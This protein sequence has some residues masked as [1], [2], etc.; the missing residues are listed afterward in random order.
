[1]FQYGSPGLSAV[2]FVILPH[3]GEIVLFPPSSSRWIS[4]E[5]YLEDALSNPSVNEISIS[6]SLEVSVTPV[7]SKVNLWG[8]VESKPHVLSAWIHNDQSSV[9]D[10]ESITQVLSAIVAEPRVC[11]SALS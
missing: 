6:Q 4:I 5:K 8:D 9:S 10:W 7:N 11:T 3:P 2:G 1:M